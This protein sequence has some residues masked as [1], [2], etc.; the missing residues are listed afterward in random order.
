MPPDPSRALFGLTGAVA[1]SP[2]VEQWL[3]TRPGELGKMARASFALLRASGSD[4][5]ELMHDGCATACVR[6]AA[7]AYV[8]AY[9]GHVSVGFFHGADLPDPNGLLEGAGKAMRHVKLRPG[10]AADRSSLQRLVVAAHDD[11]VA[12]LAARDARAPLPERV[13]LRGRQ[14]PKRAPIPQPKESR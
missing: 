12:R 3:D 9:K 6:D 7:F 4:V 2:A 14:S 10:C 13:S 11:V 1:R 8:G 5:R